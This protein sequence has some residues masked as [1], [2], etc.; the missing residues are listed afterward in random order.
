MTEPTTNRLTVFLDTLRRT[1]LLDGAQ[2]EAILTRPDAAGTDPKPLATYLLQ[3]GLLT[4]HQLTNLAAGRDAELVLGPYR[5]LDP[6]GSSKLGTTFRAQHESNRRTVT[7]KRLGPGVSSNPDTIRQFQ[8]EL[9]PVNLPPVVDAGHAGG[10]HYLAVDYAPATTKSVVKSAETKVHIVKFEAAD[11]EKPVNELA[12]LTD[13]PPTSSFRRRVQ[14]SGGS[15]LFGLAAGASMHIAAIVLLGL[16]LGGYF[17]LRPAKPPADKPEPPPVVVAPSKSAPKLSDRNVEPPPHA[18]LPPLDFTGAEI[19]RPE[20]AEAPVKIAPRLKPFEDGHSESAV[21]AAL[22]SGRFVL[23]AG[24]DGRLMLWN[25]GTGKKLRSVPTPHKV[26]AMVVNAAGTVAATAGDDAEIRLWE[27]PALT[28]IVAL[29]GPGGKPTALSFSPNGRYLLSA[30]DDK[31]V[32]LWDVTDRKAVRTLYPTHAVTALAVSPDGRRAALGTDAGPVLQYDL[33]TA[34]LTTSFGGTIGVVRGVAYS[35]DG[36]VL[37]SAGDDKSLRFWDASGVRKLPLRLALRQRLK[38]VSFA[39][40]GTWA[41]VCGDSS[42]FAAS[43]DGGWG[44]IDLNEPAALVSAAPAADG[45]GV[46]IAT[47]RGGVREVSFHGGA[48]EQTLLPAPPVGAMAKN[49]NSKAKAKNKNRP[50]VVPDEPQPTILAGA[51]LK[52]E[53][54]ATG[55]QHDVEF[56]RDGKTLLV[57]GGDRAVRVY[58]AAGGKE[59]LSVPGVANVKA[60]ACLLPDG[61]GF[62]SSGNQPTLVKTVT[63]PADCLVRRFPLD[64]RQPILVCGMAPF[65]NNEVSALAVTASSQSVVTGGPDHMLRVWSSHG[66]TIRPAKQYIT[67]GRILAVDAHP[68]L[69]VYAAMCTDGN[70]AFYRGTQV[71][72]QLA[73]SA[74]ALT[75]MKFSPDG[76]LVL[77]CGSDYLAAWDWNAGSVARQFKSPGVG[78][79]SACWAAGGA[80]V[81]VASDAGAVAYDLDSGR[82]LARVPGPPGSSHHVAVSPDGKLIAVSGR[83]VQVFELEKPLTAGDAAV[84]PGP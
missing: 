48:T 50:P 66:G 79:N 33:E 28:E 17:A 78:Q 20:P 75:T 44:A 27:L 2:L 63:V 71:I 38:G 36:T 62:V 35:P 4:R 16:F 81:A 68:K 80:A 46:Y 9:D 30:F 82:E 54:D 19:D 29:A 26:A 43:P 74:T 21:V 5:L 32:K 73:I 39:G 67:T 69:E 41:V 23:S 60:G 77:I 18:D 31:S 72:K 76:R 12:S 57:V 58:D 13:G 40:G 10:R 56:S 37:A 83:G 52:W 59:K 70:V 1:G 25:V 15:K 34:K 53:S 47:E 49:A 61:S 45:A 51:K 14:P 42:I 11:D 7:L 65:Q 22:A 24:R 64:G 6:V 8:N 3:A 55:Q 84:K